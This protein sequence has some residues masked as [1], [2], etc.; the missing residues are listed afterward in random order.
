VNPEAGTATGLSADKLDGNN[1]GAFWSGRT[2][3]NT[4]EATNSGIQTEGIARCDSGD[5][6]LGGGYRLDDSH[7]R[8]YRDELWPDEY[9]AYWL[10]GGDITSEGGQVHVL[11]A[12][13]APFRQPGIEPL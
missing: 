2:Y 4:V 6:A 9:R 10:T 7:S 8:V 3:R 1:S 12:D 5:V 11:C 13:F